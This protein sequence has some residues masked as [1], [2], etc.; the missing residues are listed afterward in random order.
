MPCMRLCFL[1]LLAFSGL[2]FAQAPQPPTPNPAPRKPLPSTR[3]MFRSELPGGTYGVAVEHI[4]SVS[5]HEYV[6]DGVARVNE[7][8]I[9]TVGNV[10]VR[11]YFLEPNKP[12]L[13]SG[14]GAAAVQKAEELF[15]QGA[16]K[17]GQD[18]A[19]K[20]VMKNYPAS[21]HSHTVEYRLEKREDLEKIFNAADEAFRTQQSK[22]VKIE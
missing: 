21:T 4:V 13:P 19:W 17:T 2:A 16:D 7:V 9:D 20:K 14:L 18:E 8:N 12:T 3:P 6:V 1:F 5:N 10:V 15:K 22:M 11:Y